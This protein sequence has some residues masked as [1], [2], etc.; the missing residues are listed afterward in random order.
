MTSHAAI[1]PRSDGR[2]WAVALGLSLLCNAAILLLAGL[3]VVQSQQYQHPNV[4]PAV[5]METV[6][7]IAPELAAQAEAP[8][9][10][11]TTDTA[12]AEATAAATAARDPEFMRT[13]DDQRSKRPDKPA[14]I[15]ER[16]TQATSDA[17][18]NPNAAAMPAQAGIQPRHE[19]D[20][21]TTESRYQDG[22]LSDAT[23]TVAES[24]QP[25]GAPAPPAPEMAPAPPAVA[26]RGEPTET[27]GVDE[28]LAPP[29]AAGHWVEGP[30]PVDVAVPLTNEEGPPKG[31]AQTLPR[32]GTPEALPTP[33]DV[34]ASPAAAS[35]QETPKQSAFRG[36][37]RKTTIQ[38]SISR[39]GRSALDVEDTP[40]GRY[41]ATISRAI[42][43]EWQRNCVRYRDFIT[44]GYLTVRFF[45]D[46]KG[47]V[48][49]PQF[50]GVMQTGQ[51]QKG[52]TLNSIHD[53]VIPA[54]PP[55]VRKDFVKE[56]LELIF[57]FYF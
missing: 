55:E 53:A 40:L 17:T 29:P 51:Q 1:A 33:D 21:E 41:Q 19:G 8:A 57:N 52:F 20:I 50:V 2:L 36:N 31:V 26:T 15:G 47:K 32:A 28:K 10:A 23:A 6:R 34:K 22:V 38:G 3:A 44:P 48:R 24:P 30:N 45:V 11:A 27:P 37:Q 16:D 49:N 39:T 35:P 42:E 54:M 12:A 14:F 5:P 46:A 7:I 18:P 25:S 13:A 4:D 56:P 43:L 9:T